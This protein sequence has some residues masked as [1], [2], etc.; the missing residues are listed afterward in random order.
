MGCPF[1]GLPLEIFK[2]SLGGEFSP[3]IRSDK[4]S[5]K[6]LNKLFK[7]ANKL[8]QANKRR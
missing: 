4:D 5:D 3:Q 2:Q 1:G 7:S 6:P 8:T